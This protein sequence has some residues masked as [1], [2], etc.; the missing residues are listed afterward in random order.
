MGAL[1]IPQCRVIKRY[2]HDT[3]APN[4]R[5]ADDG[6]DRSA[7]P[8]LSAAVVAARLAVYGDGDNRC[9]LARQSGQTSRFDASEHPIALQLGGADIGDLAE[10]ARIGADWGGQRLI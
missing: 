10:C 2:E 4:F 9:D 1:L 6:L 7:L 8:L 5:R 3:R